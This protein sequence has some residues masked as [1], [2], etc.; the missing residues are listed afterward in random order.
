MIKKIEQAHRLSDTLA[1]LDTAILLG[2][3]G[4]GKSTTVNI[5][6]GKKLKWART[7]KGAK[8]MIAEH[9]LEGFKIGI[10]GSDS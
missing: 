3:T 8:R 7:E 6:A 9:E 2:N 10:S 4:V 5:L 1:G